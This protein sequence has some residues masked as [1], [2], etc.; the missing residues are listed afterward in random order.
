MKQR[1]LLI[2][3]HPDAGRAH[4]CCA[5]EESYAQGALSGGQEVRR[6]QVTA[7]TLP[8]LQS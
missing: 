7:L 5:L 3:G 8:L 6:T 2:Q 1:I 4:L